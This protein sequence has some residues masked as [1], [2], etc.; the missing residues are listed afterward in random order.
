AHGRPARH[1]DRAAGG[2]GRLGHAATARD[3]QRGGPDRGCGP[4][5]VRVRW[6]RAADPGAAARRDAR[7]SAVIARAAGYRRLG[8]PDVNTLNMS[9]NNPQA[10]A[11]APPTHHPA[12]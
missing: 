10:V 9:W 1:R 11:Q 8:A 3:A 4:G 2:E 5:R 7:R 12:N 6:T